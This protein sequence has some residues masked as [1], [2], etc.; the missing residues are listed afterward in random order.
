[1]RV[2]SYGGGVQS[3]AALVLAAQG[4]IDYSTFL[5]C[6]T[7]DDSEH[8]D[9]LKYVRSVAMPYAAENGIDLQ[10]IQKQDK[11]GA[12]VTLYGNITKPN[13]RSIGIPVR[14]SNS[15]APGRRS[16]TYDF[17]I[18]VVDK[19]L[20]EHGAREPIQELRKAVLLRYAMKKMDKE[21]M[22][23]L[24]SDLDTFFRERVPA[25]QV[26]LGIT[27]DEMQRVKPNSDLD[28]LYWKVNT[29][30]LIFEVPKPLVRQDCIN[31][32]A[33]A[34]LPIPPKSACYFCPFHRLS[35]WQQM[36][37]DEP[38]LFWK[39]AALETFINARLKKH[40]MN[41]VWLTD[42]LKP[43]EQATTE[44]MQSSMF[45]AEDSECEGYCFV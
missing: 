14:M 32:I 41:E 43:L 34:G 10:E 1:M 5:F 35:K 44:Y 4:K 22:E 40:G 28:T 31:I 33:N 25:A 17:K 12:P 30:P 13:G 19:W 9:T 24:M 26:G 42:R 27:L 38:A 15:G 8:P 2:F 7:G 45:D 21:I 6:N 3:T 20:K 18:A 39:S 36:R 37:Q 23:R 16:C 29:H 11:S